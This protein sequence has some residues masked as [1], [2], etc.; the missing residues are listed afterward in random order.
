MTDL[1]LWHYLAIA[2][3]GVVAS[4]V[5]ILAGGGSNLILPL[6]MMFG[7]PP[8]IANGSN[9]VGILFQSLTGIR[10]FKQADKL[11][12]GD[13]R[14]ILMPMMLGGLAGSLLA[15]VLPNSVLKPALLLTML[16]VAAITFSSPICC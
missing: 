7:V 16:G 1:T 12:T 11:P 14:G 5:N 3:L 8:D 6:L 9:R 2:T 15:S 10:G 4:I 13:L